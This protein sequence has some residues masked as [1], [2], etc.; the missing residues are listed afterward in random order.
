MTTDVP[1]IAVTAGGA[2]VTGPLDGGRIFTPERLAGEHR[3]IRDAVKTFVR[4]EVDSRREALERR[5]HAAHRDLLE[6]LGRD[7]YLGI[8]VP[9]AYGG[10]GLD[11]ISSL[12]VNEAL[13]TAGSF[14]VTYAAHTGIATL[15]TVFF[16]TEAQKRRYLPGLAAGTIV[17]AYALTEPAAGSDAMAIRSRASRQPDGSWR[18]DGSKQFITNAAFADLF[19]VYAKIDGE[20]FSAFLVERSAAGLSV[21]PEENKMGLH[22][23]STC[24]VTLDS[25]SVPADNLLGEPGKGHR[26][27]FNVLNVG[28]FKLAASCLGGMRPAIGIATRYAAER[29]AFGRRLTDFPLV[30]AKLAAMVVRTYA[31]EAVVYRIAGLLDGRLATAED[32]GSPEAIRAALEEYA[33][34]CSLAKVLASEELGFVVDE[35]VQIHGG[36]G[37]IEDYPAAG[38]YR[39][40]RIHRIWEGTSEIN[41]LLVPGT[42]LKRAMTGRLDL[43]GPARRAQDALLSGELPTGETPFAGEEALVGATRTA[44]L[45]LAGAAVQ[46]YGTGLEEQQEVLAGLADLAIDLFAMESAVQRARQAVNDDSVRAPLHGNLARLVVFERA[47]AAEQRARALAASVAEGDEARTLAAGLRRLLRSDAVDRIALGRLVAAAVIEQGGYP[48]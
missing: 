39:D 44:L 10:A 40:A 27:A 46:R 29:T 12:V 45:L 8:D 20:L 11:R 30:A 36:Y 41:R 2:F 19:T 7:G 22:G 43:L 9:E 6:R 33:V 13:A 18:L 21:G 23:C 38:A 16:G 24:S 26:V 5:D 1:G 37:Y 47:G 31:V 42:L 4:R 17:G 34:E 3:A 15:P 48:V 25:V 32:A 28:R 14:S 35:L